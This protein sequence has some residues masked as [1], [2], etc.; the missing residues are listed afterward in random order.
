[1]FVMGVIGFGMMRY[2]IPAAPLLIA[3]I[4]GPLLED[5]F[6]QSMLMSASSPSILFRGPITWF[7]WGAT[8]ITVVAIVRAGIKATKGPVTL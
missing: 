3:F 4:I 8:L 5:N 6:R 7:F 2:D 1:M